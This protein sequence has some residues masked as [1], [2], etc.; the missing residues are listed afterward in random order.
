M[1]T[2]FGRNPFE[3]GTNFQCDV[4]GNPL[5]AGESQSL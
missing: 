5:E 3:A 1:N 2:T 4:I